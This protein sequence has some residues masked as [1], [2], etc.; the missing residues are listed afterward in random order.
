MMLSVP[1]DPDQPGGTAIELSIAVVRAL[2]IESQADPLFLIA[3]GPGQSTIEMY[4]GYRGA[5]EPVRL[6]RDIVLVDQRGTGESNRQSC[7]GV[8]EISDPDVSPE[9]LKAMTQQCLDELTGDPRFYTTSVAVQDLDAARAALG[10]ETINIYG[11]SYGTR[12]AQHYMR[13]FPDQTRRVILDGVIGPEFILGPDLATDADNALTAIFERCA[14][15]SACTERFGDLSASFDSLYESLEREPVTVEL[16]DP[17]S[18]ENVSQRLGH[19]ELGGVMR[20]LSYSPATVALLPMLIDSAWNQKNF[21]P[22]AAQARTIESQLESMLAIGMHNSVVCTEDAPFFDTLDIDRAALADAYLGETLFDALIAM[23]SV[24]PVGV[25]DEDFKAPLTSDIP[26]LLLSGENDPVTPPR[27]ADQALS[28]FSRHQ[29]VVG[30]RQG[31]GL[32]A[33]GCIRKLAAEFLAEEDP[34]PLDIACT[35]RLSVI[36]FFIDYQGPLR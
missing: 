16:P 33:Q 9:A 21:R 17:R 4:L 27:Y 29:H 26:V 14:E 34:L 18:G 25:M 20:L 11:V 5:F 23:C 30:A 24:W 8:T 6:E 19:Q 3:G 36:P 10:Y 13:R 32:I 22:L 12:V 7:P 35:E 2:N 31:H 1:E 15:L 28:G